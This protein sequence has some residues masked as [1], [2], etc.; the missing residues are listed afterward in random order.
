M[1]LITLILYTN[2]LILSAPTSS[3][4]KKLSGG[5]FNQRKTFNPQ[6]TATTKL[7]T[8]H[9]IVLLSREIHSKKILQLHIQMGTHYQTLYLHLPLNFKKLI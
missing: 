1:L 9:K 4:Q 8:S 3:H 5:F 7:I 2:E 6:S